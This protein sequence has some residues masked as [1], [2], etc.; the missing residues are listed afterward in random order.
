MA[1]RTSGPC[2]F[3][4]LQQQQPSAGPPSA[5][6]SPAAATAARGTYNSSI[7]GSDTL[8]LDNVR[9]SLI[10]QEETIIFSIIER[11]QFA[12]NAPVYQPGGVPVP[13]YAPDGRNFTLLEYLLRDTEAVHGRIRRYT[14]PDE[15]AFYPDALPPMVRYF[16]YQR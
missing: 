5:T 8:S 10:R 11:A 1:R 12:F 4:Q 2:P 14:S 7:D 9:T 13:A 6:A 15:H 3:I 16:W